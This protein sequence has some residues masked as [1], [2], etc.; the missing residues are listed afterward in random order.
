MNG[1]DRK[2]ALKQQTQEKKYSSYDGLFVSLVND[3]CT[4]C[5]SSDLK[6]SES[7]QI[8]KETSSSSME[9]FTYLNEELLPW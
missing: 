4:W 7:D 8:F 1:G 2:N 3:T 9:L 6:L 5:C